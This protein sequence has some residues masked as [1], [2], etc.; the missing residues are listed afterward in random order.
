MTD[1]H[2]ATTSTEVPINEFS[3]IAVT[4]NADATTNDPIFYRNAAV[5]AITE[6]ATPVGTRDSDTGEDLLIGNRSAGD[7]TWNDLIGEVWGYN[8]ILTPTEI[9][10]NY[11]A[12]KWRYR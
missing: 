5:V 3:F 7:K 1:G 8:R 10:R 11:L 4:Y 12:T 2:W 6:A 9:Q